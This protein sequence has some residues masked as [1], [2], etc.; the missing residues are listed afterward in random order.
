MLKIG[1]K[2]RKLGLSESGAATVEFIFVFPFFVGIFVSAFEV[3]MMNTRAVM[4]ERAMDLTVRDIRLSSGDT[5]QYS[6][7]LD[8][9]CD[10]TTLI[11]NC[12]STLR[13]ELTAIDKTDFSGISS[14]AD[15]VRRD[16]PVQPVVK[17]ENGS[18]DELM[19]IRICAIVDPFFPTIGVGRTMPKDESGGYQIVAASAFVNE[20]V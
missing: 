12:K 5:L 20:P 4:L 11:P 3:A 19:L 15:C 9:I 16:L 13:I 14:T 6:D 10:Q 18:D 2:L 17:F 1:K 7:I 8:D